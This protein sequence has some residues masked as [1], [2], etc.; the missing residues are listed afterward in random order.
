M[1]QRSARIAAAMATAEVSEP[2]RPSV[3]MRRGGGMVARGT[4]AAQRGDAA[5]DGIDAL[6]AGDDRDFLAILEPV[7]DLAAVD[8]DDARR[9]MGLAGLDR[10]LPALPGSRLD[11]DRLQRDCQQTGGDLLA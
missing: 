6:E 8:G 5:G 1:S 2:P 9:G 7:D 10:D 11:A 3:A 4:A